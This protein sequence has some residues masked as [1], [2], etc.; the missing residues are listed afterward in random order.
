MKEPTKSRTLEIDGVIYPIDSAAQTVNGLSFP[1]FLDTL[2]EDQKLRVLLTLK[3]IA[4]EEKNYPKVLSEDDKVYLFEL[5]ND[6]ED[7]RD[8]TTNQTKKYQMG[9]ELAIEN[10]TDWI[11][12]KINNF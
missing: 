9:L 7:A 5:M 6:I 4:R 8:F 1:D 11:E 2:P 12:D 3:K 10:L